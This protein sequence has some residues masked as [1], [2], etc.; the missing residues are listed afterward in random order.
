MNAEIGKDVMDPVEDNVDILQPTSDMMDLVWTIALPGF[1]AKGARMREW[2]PGLVDA[3]SWGQRS[4]HHQQKLDLNASIPFRV[5]MYNGTT[6]MEAVIVLEAHH[7]DHSPQIRDSQD[8]S[9]DMSGF[10]AE[11]SQEDGVMKILIS[12]DVVQMDGTLVRGVVRFAVNLTL[13]KKIEKSKH[14]V[15]WIYA[16]G[17]RAISARKRSK[18]QLGEGLI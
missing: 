3:A 5:K 13:V 16:P 4:H 2:D 10:Q 8:Q 7:R 11:I 6:R 9:E 14:Q 17:M 15:S 1:G 12:S 18:A